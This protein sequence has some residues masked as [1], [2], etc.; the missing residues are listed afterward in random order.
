MIMVVARRASRLP[1]SHTTTSPGIA[2]TRRESGQGLAEA[3]RAYKWASGRVTGASDR[4][5]VAQ[6]AEQ[7]PVKPW[8]ESSSLSPR[9]TT[10][11]VDVS[12]LAVE[13]S[14]A[15]WLLNT[16]RIG[17]A[18]THSGSGREVVRRGP[19]LT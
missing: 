7:R 6:S 4:S 5:G 13:H 9:A 16:H 2:S 11:L 10:W 18:S 14:L 17:T 1:S 19:R 3:S 12:G 8:V 15:R